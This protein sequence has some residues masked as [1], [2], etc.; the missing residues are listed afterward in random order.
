MENVLCFFN[1]Y[2]KAVIQRLCIVESPTVILANV[3]DPLLLRIVDN[4]VIMMIYLINQINACI[5]GNK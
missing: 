4:N 1:L 3:P 5:I 2:D